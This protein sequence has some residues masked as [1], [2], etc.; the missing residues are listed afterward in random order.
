M[1]CSGEAVHYYSN[2]Q[3]HG[4]FLTEVMQEIGTSHDLDAN[5]VSISNNRLDSAFLTESARYLGAAVLQ[6]LTQN[7]LEAGGYIT[8]AEVTRYYSRYFSIL[9]FTRLNGYA[10]LHL[11][12]FRDSEKG[13][14]QYWVI[15]TNE[16]EHTYIIFQRK[17][18]K[19]VRDV[20]P[21]EIPS[22]SGSHK[23]NWKLMA[24][25]GKVWDETELQKAGITS[26]SMFAPPFDLG[27]SYEDHLQYELEERSRWNYLTEQ[28]GFF[29]GELDG[30][31][32]W[33]ND[34]ILMYP[35]YPN[36]LSEQSPMEDTWEYKMTWS[37]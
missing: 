25:I 33:R 7:Y 31:N 4:E 30:I 19:R 34:N 26:P 2:I 10:T 32:R 3:S 1:K 11:H 14:K 36:P 12:L 20:L 18:L 29:F 8:W 5:T 21:I 16:Q 23:T 17:Q 22:G 27:A 35:Y 9:A 24:Q 13:T 28:E 37:T 6:F 15:R